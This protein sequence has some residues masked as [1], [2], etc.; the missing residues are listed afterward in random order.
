MIG[1]FSG[2]LL[3]PAVSEQAESAGTPNKAVEAKAP[4][5]MK[6]RRDKDD[7]FVMNSEISLISCY[8]IFFF[9]Y[10]VIN[11]N[12]FQSGISPYCNTIRCK[13]SNWVCLYEI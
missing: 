3:F 4:D 11:G 8:S 6:F 9:L 12:C 7:L 1:N 2:F 13:Y 10:F 5:F